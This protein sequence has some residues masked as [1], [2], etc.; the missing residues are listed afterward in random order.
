MRLLIVD[1][2][3]HGLDLAIRA[4]NAGH[5]VK[6]AIRLDARTKN[7]GRGF[8]TVVRDHR[9]WLRWAN[10]IV[11]TDN[12]LYLHDLESHRRLA[13]G[14]VIAPS[15]EAAQWELD[16]QLGQQVFRRA[17][18]PTIPCKEFRSYDDAIAH[19]KKTMRRFV[20][21]PCNDANADKAL[22]YCSAGPDDMVYMLERWKRSDKLKGSF[23]LQDFIPGI[24]FGVAAWHGPHG[25]NDAFEETFEFKKLMNG[26]IGCATGE[27]GTV[28]RY[29]RK[30]K[31]AE[32]VL[33]PLAG[34]LEKLKY[35]GDV[36]INC[37]I[38]EQG[39][40]WPLEFTMRLGWPAFQ[41]QCALLKDDPVTW[42]HDLAT[43]KDSHPFFLDRLAVGV[44]LSVP[45]YPYSHMTRK[46]VTGIPILGITPG[47]MKHLHPCEMMVG[48][49]Y[50]EVGGQLV[51]TPCPMTAGDYVLVMTA[52][53][54]TVQDAR[55]KVY[56]RLER[57]RSRMPGSPMYRTDIGLRLAR[58]LPKLQA[59]GYAKGL[60]FS[61]PPTSSTS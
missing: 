51:R 33:L 52:C 38:D 48:E 16:R 40:P 25:F 9:E 21:K 44:V 23:I 8:V 39:H 3:G 26:E 30:S 49:A 7:I 6:L 32:K 1:P 29:V 46:E 22:S 17:N 34:Q 36:A 50:S 28:M 2:P 42:L 4:Q 5:E 55:Q 58:Q 60:I 56:R 37:I 35:I 11:C 31:L 53:G 43:G 59:Q 13:G 10:L 54:E 57:V 20:S 41:L 15:P 18:I 45:D 19:V 12:S 47:L 61:T 24:E 14:L 27:Q